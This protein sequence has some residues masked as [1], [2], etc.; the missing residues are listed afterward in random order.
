[1]SEHKTKENLT[2]EII[3][4]VDK[5][6]SISDDSDN[7]EK[8]ID[9]VKISKEFQEN[10]VKF[11][12]LDDLIRK[13]QK[14][15]CDLKEQKKPC[16]QFILK[17]LDQIEENVI[18]ITNGKLRKNKSETKAALS[19]DVIKNA[20]SE[21]IKDSKTVEDILSLMDTLRPLNTHVNLKRTNIRPNRIVKKK[22]IGDK[23][24]KNDKD[25]K[26]DDDADRLDDK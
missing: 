7:D 22:K 13:K 5:D 16:E 3:S 25:N 17:F 14:E 19:Q 20:I 8:A 12:K 2:S 15:I 1:M 10:V 23:E 6:D 18:E 26:S 9:K 24:E 11:V 21:K 4:E